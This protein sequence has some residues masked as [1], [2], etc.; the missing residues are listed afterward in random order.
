MTA[1]SA[2]R[3][4]QH[5]LTR[6]LAAKGALLFAERAPN[7][8]VLVDFARESARMCRTLPFTASLS[9]LTGLIGPVRHSADAVL[10]FVQQQTHAVYRHAPLHR[11]I[12]QQIWLLSRALSPLAA[13]SHFVQHSFR[14][15]PPP[16]LSYI[17][18]LCFQ[19]RLQTTHTFPVHGRSTATARVL[20]RL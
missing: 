20:P 7:S 6:T 12:A 4:R 17:G 15:R 8:L 16:S 9:E 3:R 13:P 11:D 18:S 2:R 5:K 19:L 14:L 10:A 1:G